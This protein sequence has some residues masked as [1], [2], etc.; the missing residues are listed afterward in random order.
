MEQARKNPGLTLALAEES[1]RGLERRALPGLVHR[2]QRGR[3]HPD[4]VANE[5]GDHDKRHDGVEAAQRVERSCATPFPSASALHATTPLRRG[6]SGRNPM[7]AI[8]TETR[9]CGTDP[10]PGVS[11]PFA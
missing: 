1:R 11:G 2:V 10:A 4:E 9:P 5:C 8:G 3:G 6:H 7:T